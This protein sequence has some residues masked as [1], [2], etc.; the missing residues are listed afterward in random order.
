MQQTE[1]DC[2][3]LIE[4]Q[5]NNWKN[6]G[7][8]G[9]W[10]VCSVHITVLYLLCCKN[11]QK[12]IGWKKKLCHAP[13]KKRKKKSTLKIL[14]FYSV[15]NS[16]W[17]LKIF[18][19]RPFW[20]EM[21]E[22][23]THPPPHEVVGQVG[24]QHVRTERGLHRTLVDL[25]HQRFSISF[26]LQVDCMTV[27]YIIYCS[28]NLKMPRSILLYSIKKS[29]SLLMICAGISVFTAKVLVYSLNYDAMT[30]PLS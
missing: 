20:M 3:Q 11:N 7:G 12:N 5:I 21:C 9:V 16:D 4:S 19:Q 18:F 8:G 15:S 1:M 10:H 29:Q 25:Q 28:G 30:V 17:I 24:R 14:T 22:C 26:G 2:N 27:H 23:R 6:V 13:G